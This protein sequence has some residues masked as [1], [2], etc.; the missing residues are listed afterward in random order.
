MHRIVIILLCSCIF[1]FSYG[2]EN[3]LKDPTSGLITISNVLQLEGRTKA[4]L[5]ETADL[6]VNSYSD[7]GLSFGKQKLK[8]QKVPVFK[9]KKN[10]ESDSV[11]IYE[12]QYS[13]GTLGGIGA[14][15]IE[16]TSFKLN[17]YIKPGKVK[18]E[19]TNFYYQFYNQNPMDINTTQISGK[20][21][22]TA[23][24]Q[25][26]KSW[27]MKIWTKG[28]ITAIESA[29]LIA[30]AIEDYFSKTAKSKFDF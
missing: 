21:E 23:P 6:F 11:L 25:G 29:Q 13:R 24:E 2:Q 16:Y 20:L 1:K 17:F 8:E 3:S 28:K 18:Y 14:A 15:E 7:G 9:A 12:C 26:D 4:S 5:K 27:R 30:K 10:M 19:L 22:N